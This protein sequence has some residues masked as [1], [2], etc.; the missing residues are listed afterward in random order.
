VTTLRS[1][2]KGGERRSIASK[3]GISASFYREDNLKERVGGLGLR[4]FKTDYS[5]NVFPVGRKR[6]KGTENGGF[7]RLGVGRKTQ[8]MKG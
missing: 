7:V 1:P 5:G 4:K 2:I 3:N 6:C 8:K